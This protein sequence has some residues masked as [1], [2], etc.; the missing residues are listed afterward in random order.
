MRLIVALLFLMLGVAFPLLLNG[1]TFTNSLVGI[2]FASA[3]VALGV[4]LARDMRAT[5]ARLWAGRIVVG[6]AVLLAALSHG[7]SSDA[8]SFSRN[9]S[10][11]SLRNSQKLRSGT[12]SPSRP[13]GVGP[14]RRPIRH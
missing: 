3:A 9:S 11:V 6:L 1:Q 2:A 4:G 8:D 12:L 14:L 5:E 13:H 10:G 7:V